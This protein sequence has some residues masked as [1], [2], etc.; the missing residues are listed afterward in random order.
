MKKLYHLVMICL[1]W[2]VSISLFAQNPTEHPIFRGDTLTFNGVVKAKANDAILIGANILVR[3]LGIGVAADANGFFSLRLPPGEYTL[4][5]SYIGY[6]TKRYVL[7][8]FRSAAHTFYLEEQIN[9]L[10]EIEVSDQNRDQNVSSTSIGV[11]RL[12]IKSIRELPT[13]MGEAD[14]VRGIQTLPGVTTVG[15]GATGFNV[16]GGNIDQNLLL[17]DDIP[18]FNTSHLMGFI[19]VFNPDAVRNVDFYRGGI[20]ATYSGRTASVLDI[21]LRE[22]SGERI[23]YQGGIGLIA[24]RLTIE[25]PLIKNKLNFLIAGRG[26]W[27]DYLF[28]LL[29][30]EGIKDTRANYYDLTAKLNY[31]LGE[32]SQLF[33]TGYLSKDA[34]KISGDSLTSLEVNASSTLFK[35][36]TAGANLR[37]N[38]FFNNQFSFNASFTVSDYQPQFSI[39]DEAYAAKFTSGILYQN[40]KAEANYFSEQH[41][42]RT[43]VSA[44]TYR[45]R[46]G[47][48]LP[49]SPLSAIN[50]VEL[51]E[52]KGLELG[53]YINDTWQIGKRLSL[54]LG[55]RYSWFG[56]R[57]PGRVY[58]YESDKPIDIATLTDTTFFNSGIIEQYSGL[59]PRAALRLALNDQV[60]VKLG[61]NR[62]IQ[63]VQLVTNTTSALPTARWKLS[64]PYIQPQIADQLSI[65]YFHNFANDNI[66]A[67]VELYYKTLENM[68]DYRSGAN[69][70]LL[71]ATETV[72]LQ[73]EG[74]S[75]GVE[76]LLRKNRGRLNGWLSY[77]FSQS[78]ILVNSPYP[79][80]ALF[81]GAYYP[82]NFNRPHSLSI[83]ANYRQSRRVTLSAN[84]TYITGRPATFPA[85]KYFVG[86][87]FLP[88]FSDRNQDKIPD[89][90]RLDI[91][92]TLE[93]NPYNKKRW[94]GR[95]TFSLY[96][97]YARNNAFSIFFKTKNPGT[98]NSNGRLGSYRLSVIGS[99]VPSITYDF[100]F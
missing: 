99:V 23:S 67:S 60:S 49:D 31:K 39:P 85:D 45:I 43:G 26:A 6:E 2:G 12:G 40:A 86:G 87:V 70:L 30:E 48:L 1:L 58:Q 76:F 84:F 100:K 63:Y 98:T 89:Y 92:L 80:D 9:Y 88:N 34:F 62:M 82:T 4:E 95:W 24:N 55:L 29:P 8:L 53:I 59:E 72:I 16:R 41:E 54:M 69:L 75:Y 19:S 61:Y 57:G 79:E 42:V 3:G 90:H 7:S 77:T 50:R 44:T 66:E 65:G 52:E 68:P 18:I 22:P 74:R 83:I 71:D 21:S 96:N 32:Q 73:G 15:E 47:S 5:I 97:F 25:G 46:P 28:P 20:P 10:E 27:A 17:M 38:Y 78:D 64:D 13:L 91:G 36:K 56:L 81:S 35:W 51:P 94:Q 33:L 11:T 37:W 14:I 93:P